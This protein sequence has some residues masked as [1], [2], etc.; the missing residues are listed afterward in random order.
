M[1]DLVTMK[2]IVYS[3]EDMG[4]D[5][6]VEE[7]PAE[8]KDEAEVARE[9]MCETLGENDE[10]FME[11][12]LEG[13]YNDEGEIR[14][15]IRRATLS[16]SVVPVLCGSA[17]KNKGVQ[18]L[19]D[20]VVDYLPSPLDVPPVEGVSPKND[21]EKMVRKAETGEPFSALAFKIMTDPFCW[22]PNLLTSLFGRSRIGS[23]G[24]EYQ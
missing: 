8:L 15:A 4:K 1:I 2:A 23:N 7:I 16:F 9:K 12:F 24:D 21:E 10:H 19:L 13:N 11:L 6:S 17:F 22:A 3:N 18:P 5:P 20:A 14:A